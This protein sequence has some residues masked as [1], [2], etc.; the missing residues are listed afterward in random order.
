MT[1]APRS[2]S[3]ATH[4]APATPPAVSPAAPALAALALCLAWAVPAAGAPAAVAAAR[5]AATPAADRAAVAPVADPL[6]PI[7]VSQRAARASGLRVGDVVRV[8]PDPGLRD[9]RL[10]RVAGIMPLKA[11]PVDVGRGTLWVKMRL[12]DLAAVQDRPDDVDEII[13]KTR[14]PADAGLVRD[15]LNSL[16]TGYRAYTSE[17]LAR[18]TTQTFEVISLFHRAI[19]II[20]LVAGAVF[21]LAILVFK[22]EERRR[23]LGALRLIGVHRRSLVLFLCAEALGISLVGSAVGLVLGRVTVAA[24]N[25]Y[26]Q[27]F[28]DTTLVFAALTPLVAWESVLLGVGFGLAAGLVVALRVVRVPPLKLLGR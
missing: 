18:R 27:R 17:E 14:T 15:R 8:S 19:S 4:L 24:L 1:P 12:S 2:I 10:A 20:T 3:P 13:L 22:A 6:P 26:Y 5:P 25:A 23:E 9:A 11:D 21:L 28:Y 7:L 16:G